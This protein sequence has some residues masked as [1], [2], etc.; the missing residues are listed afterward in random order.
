MCLGGFLLAFFTIM[1]QALPA[2]LM[3]YWWV[4]WWLWRA[5]CT[6]QDTYLLYII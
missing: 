4:G 6:L 1:S 3:P 2:H 5:G